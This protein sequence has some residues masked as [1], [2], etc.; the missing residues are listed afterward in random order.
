MGIL[1]SGRRHLVMFPNLITKQREAG[2]RE[3]VQMDQARL[4]S[5]QIIWLIHDDDRI[6]IKQH[7]AKC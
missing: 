4:K 3:S 2:P 7:K 6:I 1:T 5:N